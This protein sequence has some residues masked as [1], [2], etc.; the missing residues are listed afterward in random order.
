M[1]ISAAKIQISINKELLKKVDDYA[2]SLFISRSGLISQALTQLLQA[3]SMINAIVTTSI[4]LT[5][6][7]DT[8]QISDDDMRKLKDFEKFVQMV[9][10]G[11]VTNSY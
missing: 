2:E 10:K 11:N 5:R 4:A 8:G 7:A 9:T 1:A 6:I 3:D